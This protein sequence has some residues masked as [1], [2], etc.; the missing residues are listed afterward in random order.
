[1]QEPGVS[2]QD[3]DEECLFAGKR[4]VERA[5]VDA[6]FAQDRGDARRVES[7]LVEEPG[8]GLEDAVLRVDGADPRFLIERSFKI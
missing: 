7:L 2:L 6:G 8:G 3:A 5:C 4:V 1:V